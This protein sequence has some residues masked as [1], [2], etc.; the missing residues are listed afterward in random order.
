MVRRVSV[1]SPWFQ[2]FFS[3]FLVV[4]PLLFC[5]WKITL[6]NN[7]EGANVRQLSITIYIYGHLLDNQS[8]FTFDHRVPLYFS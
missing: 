6:G 5:F 3:F 1:V 2:E 7:L 4:I 8:F